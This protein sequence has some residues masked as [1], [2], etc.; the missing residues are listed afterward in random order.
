MQIEELI[1]K[2]EDFG[3]AKIL[4]MHLS[5]EPNTNISLKIRCM[6]A[7]N[8]YAWEVLDLIFEGVTSYRFN[9]EERTCSVVIDTAL[10]KSLDI[11]Y[12]FDFFPLTFENN[13]LE[14]NPLSDLL[15]RCKSVK[16]LSA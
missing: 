1:N 13:L 7:Q 4:N 3:D 8:N 9:Q 15:I 10:F 14:I 16:L 2:Y 11:G 5:T 12:V 6:N